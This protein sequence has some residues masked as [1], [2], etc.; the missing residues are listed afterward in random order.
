MHAPVLLDETIAALDL[1]EGDLVIDG[2]LGG[3]GH[4]KAILARVGR[5]GRLLGVDRDETAL[6]RARTALGDPRNAILIQGSYAELPDILVREKLPKANALL[7]DLGLSSD[8]LEA[9]GRGFSFQRDEPLDMRFDARHEG[10]T[11]AALIA[12]ASVSELARILRECGEEPHAEKFARVIA[13]ARRREPIRT[14]GALARIIERAAGGRGRIHPATK[15]FM[16]L[17]IAVNH[18][19][20]AL[21][22]LIPSLRRVVK[23]GGRVAVI[24]FHSVEDRVVKEGFRALAKEGAAEILT[25]HVVKPSRAEILANPRSRSAKLRSLQVT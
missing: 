17:R 25:K 5:S 11:A 8:Q 10:E 14:S 23:P 16:A 2:T 21:R 20:D 7:L 6:T 24:S 4:A 1:H 9:G 19:L 12:R 22:T 13:D 3:G 18:E 15:T